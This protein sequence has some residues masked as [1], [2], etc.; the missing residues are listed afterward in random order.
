MAN[1]GNEIILL[2]DA[3]TWNQGFL[4]WA[5][6][7]QDVIVYNVMSDEY[8]IL[9]DD[10]N[11]KSIDMKPFRHCVFKCNDIQRNKSC[12][13]EGYI[14]CD[15]KHFAIYKH[16]NNRPHSNS[17]TKITVRNKDNVEIPKQALCASLLNRNGKYGI[18]DIH[19]RSL[20]LSKIYCLL[21]YL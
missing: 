4:V 13:Q 21:F 8:K 14:S 20:T 1:N 17:I 18:F 10:E 5:P 7:R 16:G 9:S 12:H 2:G 11:Y 6:N 15:Y 3:T 19:A